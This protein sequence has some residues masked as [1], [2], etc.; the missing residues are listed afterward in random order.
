MTRT[1]AVLF[2]LLLAAT[3]ARSATDDDPLTA[4]ARLDRAVTVAAP[5]ATLGTVL[6]QLSQQSGVTLSADSAIAEET[7]VAIVRDR[8]AREL[9]KQLA[10]ALGYSWKREKSTPVSYRLFEADEA[11]AKTKTLAR[12]YRAAAAADLDQQ[13]KLTGKYLD[14][15]R[16]MADRE[17]KADVDR[18]RSESMQLPVGLE[19]LAA[20]RELFAAER[21]QEPLT[22]ALL[23]AYALLPAAAQQQVREG[24]RTLMA[25][26]R[27]AALR[28][29]P[30]LLA[31]LRQARQFE[32]TRAS[33]AAG[34]PPARQ[35][36][37]EVIDFISGMRFGRLVLDIRGRY[38]GDESPRP[39]TSLPWFTLSPSQVMYGSPL[40]D[41]QPGKVTAEAPDALDRRV[42]LMW[43]GK[44][45]LPED[46]LTYCRGILLPEVLRAL[47]D[48][49]PSFQFVGDAYFKALRPLPQ[50]GNVPPGTPAGFD[51][52]ERAL[53][54]LTLRTVREGA[55]PLRDV[56][57]EL[58]NRGN[59]NIHVAQDGWVRF[60]STVYFND[61]TAQLDPRV[62]KQLYG[63]VAGGQ[64]YTRETAMT[65]ARRLN[66][67]QVEALTAEYLAF[68]PEQRPVWRMRTS[69]E[70]WRMIAS[71]TE[72]HRQKLWSRQALRYGALT[73]GERSALREVLE[74]FSN[75]VGGAPLDLDIGPNDLGALTLS[76][77]IPERDLS[78]ALELSL[79]NFARPLFQ[80]FLQ[81]QEGT[82]VAPKP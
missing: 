28:M 29:P 17:I 23:T 68:L 81:V 53:S 42:N 82:P 62:V 52:A 14:Q 6:E 48:R 50:N 9:M 30:D 44:K 51:P 13:L 8:P 36:E 24:R 22:R 54:R 40:T 75:R 66:Y 65:V 2:L 34:V 46:P 56:L 20:E 80:Q 60:R 5:L 38:L 70:A 49:E 4:D 58:A 25:S 64:P 76:L 19:R 7:V 57:T 35:S 69:W 72:E 45:V 63:P 15:Y 41:N 77:G 47:A 59:V 10:L 18:L 71:L 39:A 11:K 31:T 27:P 73:A 61:R 16:E 78:G 33:R 1:I 26:V 21:A 74:E 12:Q 43:T 67:P 55:V 79:P 3:C 37:D 32:V